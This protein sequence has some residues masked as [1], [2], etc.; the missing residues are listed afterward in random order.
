[1]GHLPPPRCLANR[2]PYVACPGA[3][4]TGRPWMPPNCAEARCPWVAHSISAFVG[5]SFP[6]IKAFILNASRSNSDSYG[7]IEKARRSLPLGG[8]AGADVPLDLCLTDLENFLSRHLAILQ[9]AA[10]A[11]NA[12]AMSTM[13]SLI[14]AVTAIRR[15]A[16]SSSSSNETHSAAPSSSYRPA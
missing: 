12:T 13:D 5:G 6:S 7:V 8:A 1:M 16:P 10:T 2:D 4:Q 9:P 11:A 15:G 3:W 14:T